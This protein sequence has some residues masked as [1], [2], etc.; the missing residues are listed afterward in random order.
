MV[1]Q[2]RNIEK[3]IEPLFKVFPVISITGPRQS[4]KSTMLKHYMNK[5]WK[6]FNLD[7]R[8]LLIKAIDDPDLFVKD[9]NSNVILDEVQKAPI[10]FHSI[11]KIVDEG[12]KWKII[13]SG[14]ANFLLMKSITESLAGRAGILELLPF[15]I[16][17]S[18]SIKQGGI[19]ETILKSKNVKELYKEISPIKP[20]KEEKLKN[21]ILH[22][23]FPKVHNL[24]SNQQKEQ[25]FQ[26]YI[27]TY[28]EKDLRDIAKIPELGNFQTVYNM[29]CYQSG[30]VL[31]MSHI[32]SDVGINVNTVKNYISILE[33]S[34]QFKKLYP[35]R[36]QRN[37]IL[38]KNPKI[39]SLDTGIINFI[40]KNFDK[41][42]MLTSGYWG[43]I[44]E[45][46]VFSEIYKSIKNHLHR[47]DFY[48]YR[49]K[50]NAE[51]DF[52]LQLGEK[53]IPIEIKSSYQIK[54]QVLRGLKLFIESYSRYKV[55]YG[56]IF[57]R[58]EHVTYLDEKIIGVPLTFLY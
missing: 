14:S 9:F 27:T 6:Y 16:S 23:G 51:I 44:L 15:S 32:S 5:S 45:S 33:T 53:I 29:L 57:Y 56:I 17:E 47:P 21:F 35:F 18:L 3:E 38:V 4:G 50:N 10:L 39:F 42:R 2:K 26:N 40:L 7:D 30:N 36:I 20:I 55:E 49:T 41:E 25:W 12:F 31:N 22:G 52:I 48:F 19:V 34:Y 28:I 11:K 54:P 13:L 8:S 1:Y 24:N 43:N 58:G 37:K 46:Y